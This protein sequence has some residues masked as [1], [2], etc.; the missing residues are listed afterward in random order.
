MFVI[1]APQAEEE[2]E[3][4][5]LTGLVNTR[6]VDFVMTQAGESRAKAA[7]ALKE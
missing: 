4:N 2:D 6:D 7:K 3:D 1:T 5:D